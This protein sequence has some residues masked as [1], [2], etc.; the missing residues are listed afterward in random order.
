MD[1]EKAALA[2]RFQAGDLD[3]LR[4]VVEEYQSKICRLGMRLLGNVQEAQDLAQDTFLRAY[5]KRSQ[6]HPDRPLEPWLLKIALNLGRM[7]LRRR[8]EI[9]MEEEKH[10]QSVAAGQEDR[11]LLTEQQIHVQRALVQVAPKFRAALALRFEAD[12]SLQEIA[13][14]LNISLGT[15]KSRL[16]RGLVSFKQAYLALGGENA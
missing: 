2:A 12:L 1:P 10:G 5:E 9:P 3:A 7:R 6:Y 14:V 4:C 8:R 13:S 11:V 15:V 16:S